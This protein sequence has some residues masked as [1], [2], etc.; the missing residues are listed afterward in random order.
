MAP[1]SSSALS[2]ASTT[3]SASPERSWIS[4]TRTGTP[5]VIARSPDAELGEHVRR[6]AHDSRAVPQQRVRP[7]GLRLERVTGDG[8]DVAALVHRRARRRK[9]TAA[10][11][12]LDH[13]DGPRPAGDHAVAAREIGFPGAGA[14]R[15]LAHERTRL[16]DA[17][18]QIAVLERIEAVEPRAENGDGPARG[19]E[20]AAVRGRVDPARQPRDHDE[21]R[22]RE[23]PGEALGEPEP[24]R[25]R[26]ARAHDRNRRLALGGNQRPSDP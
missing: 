6:A 25:A 26:R 17:V 13:D 16:A 18:R 1:S 22:R 5:R 19:G 3:G 15:E 2:R 24:E 9:R 4:S 23:L 20:S 14:E 10:L 7:F 12:R 11:A 8:H 21:A